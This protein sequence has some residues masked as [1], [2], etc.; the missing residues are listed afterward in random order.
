MPKFHQS[1]KHID[2]HS[3]A[4]LTKQELDAKHLAALDAKSIVSW[5]SPSRV[6]KA[7]S[8]KYFIKISLYALVF[9]LAAIA[10]GEF[11]L[12]GVIIAIVFVVFVFAS[13]APE[14]V[15]HKINN[16][17]IVSG[18]R[19]YLWEEL[20]S[21]WFEK[22]GDDMV[23]MVQTK[24]HFPSRLIMILTKISERTLLDVIEK[25]IHFHSS[26]VHTLFDKWAHSLLKRVN[27]DS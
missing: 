12:V 26:P 27:L 14:T 7:R 5:K 19:A 24:L 25:H 15:E 2:H 23:L 21:F 13:Q 6:F 17:G 22:K 18:G 9:I 8:Q 1:E 3:G 4:E 11:F 20:D 10:F 16:I